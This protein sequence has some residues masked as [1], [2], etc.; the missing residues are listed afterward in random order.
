[1][2]I[3]KGTEWNCVSGADN[4]VYLALGFLIIQVVNFH[5]IGRVIAAELGAP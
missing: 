2:G 5:F 1:V 4:L 3:I